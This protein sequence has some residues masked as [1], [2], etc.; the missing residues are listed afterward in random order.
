VRRRLRRAL[1]A[2]A[3]TV[4][5]IDCDF[6]HV[7]AEIPR[8]LDAVGAGADL[9]LGSRYVPG[10]G[11]EGWAPWRRAASRAGC[12]YARAVLRV[13]VRDLTGGLKCFRAEALEAIAFRTA[14]S[15]GYAF[16]VE[17][18]Y[19]ALRRPARRRAADHVPRAARGRVEV[20]GPRRARGRLADSGAPSRARP[21]RPH[22][23]KSGRPAADP[24][25]VRSSMEQLALVRGWDDTLATLRR[26][27]ARPLSAVGPWA[28][29]SLAVAGLLLAATWVVALLSVPDPMLRGRT[30]SG[31]WADYGFIVYRNGLVLA[32]H[33][34]ACV[35]GFI[36]GSTLPVVA[37]GHSGRWR[38][39]HDRAGR[40]ALVFVA[41]ATLFSLATQAYAL[42]PQAAGVADAHD[43][44]P[45][46]LIVSLLPHAIPELCALFL[47][48]AAWLCASRRQAWDELLAATFVT[49]AIAV[50]VILAAAAV[51]V[52][53]SPYVLSFLK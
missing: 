12:A 4:C 29:G 25:R 21:R 13:P 37:E 26:W 47:P 42:G 1:A 27:R 6:S 15:R 39:V 8:L 43:I 9:A 11:V 5:E 51:E 30:G 49:T 10:G 32:L 41:A 45:A 40:L 53:L 17:L 34:M 36:A 35:A 7:P 14:G 24:G 33:A 31:E 38:R 22:A 28:L 48:L 23:L 18:T 16:Q 20:D 44:S 52:W 2:G 3:G 46:L 50:P 19:R